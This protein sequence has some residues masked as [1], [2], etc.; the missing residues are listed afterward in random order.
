[1]LSSA[2]VL[3]GAPP[4]PGLRGSRSGSLLKDATRP[5][6]VQQTISS[7]PVE[8]TDPQQ[9]LW[10]ASLRFASNCTSGTGDTS[11]L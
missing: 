1:M 7:K 3:P 4:L 2:T 10:M 11:K 9:R 5:A 8:L 6:K